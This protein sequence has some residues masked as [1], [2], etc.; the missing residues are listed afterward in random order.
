M[1][2]VKVLKLV[3]LLLI[4]VMLVMIVFMISVVI[5]V[6]PKENNLY[7][8][9]TNGAFDQCGVEIQGVVLHTK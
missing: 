8:L 3:L 5:H 6:A 9:E 7:R 4:T 1:I 2:I